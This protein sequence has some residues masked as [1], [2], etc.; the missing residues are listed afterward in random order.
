MF[1]KTKIFLFYSII[2]TLI[3][4]FSAC[5]DDCKNK[6]CLNGA[7]CNK[8][9][10]LC[11][12]GY[13]GAECASEWVAKFPKNFTTVTQT[14]CTKPP[15]SSDIERVDLMRLRI[16]NL[17]GYIGVGGC[18]NYYVTAKLVSSTAFVID[19]VFCTDFHITGRGDYDPTTQ[20]LKISYNCIYNN[21]MTTDNCDAIYQY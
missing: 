1:Q 20:K 6:T 19:D 8:G 21:N 15:F 14:A 13:E 3:G 16:R 17:G 2:I 18:G 9:V 12:T 5:K 10:C 11:V 4:F 7:E